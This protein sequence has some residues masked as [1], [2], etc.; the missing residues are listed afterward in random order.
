MA[1]APS[2]FTN[3]YKNY[4]LEELEKKLA[5]LKEYSK[6]DKFKTLCEDEKKREI[7]DGSSLIDLNSEMVA[8]ES[9]IKKL[10]KDGAYIG[11]PQ[12]ISLIK[13][14]KKSF[15]L[16]DYLTKE[17][18][19]SERIANKNVADFDR[20]PDIKKEFEEY[21]QTEQFSSNPICI[22]G[23]TAQKLTET[24]SLEALGAYNFLIWLKEDP[25]KALEDLKRNLPRK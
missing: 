10:K 16:F 9:M 18:K 14:G 3:R 20:H 1:C 15:S 5:E 19:Y 4:S 12:N 6:S 11:L 2:M 25:N 24:T 17:K 13:G 7:D 22:E 21:I 23:Y 8:I